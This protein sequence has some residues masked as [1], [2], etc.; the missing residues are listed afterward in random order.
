MDGAFQS[1]PGQQTQ[2][3]KHA[4]ESDPLIGLQPTTS[5]ANDQR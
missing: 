2:N 3:L 4:H 1:D 5:A